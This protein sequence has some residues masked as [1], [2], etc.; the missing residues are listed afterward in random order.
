MKLENARKLVK[1]ELLDEET[2]LQ[3]DSINE[4]K[5][6]DIEEEKKLENKLSDLHTESTLGQE[7]VVKPKLA[8][9]KKN[10][11]TN[12]IHNF[13]PKS[14]ISSVKEDGKNKSQNSTR[15]SDSF[16]K[17]RSTFKIRSKPKVEN[18]IE[19][20]NSLGRGKSF[21]RR[22]NKT[23]DYSTTQKPKS[24]SIRRS[25][26]NT[27]ENKLK[28]STSSRKPISRY[29]NAS[30]GKSGSKY[31]F[32]RTSTTNQINSNSIGE[33]TENPVTMK[34]YISVTR[35]LSTT[36]SEEISTKKLR[37]K[38]FNDLSRSSVDETRLLKTKKEPTKINETTT[39]PTTTLATKNVRPTS[40][41]SRN[42]VQVFK[43]D[44]I[45]KSNVTNS[46]QSEKKIVN[47]TQKI[48]PRSRT[49]TYRRHSEV[50]QSLL[51]S[52]TVEPN[53]IEITP[54]ATRFQVS[55]SNPSPQLVTQEPVV[56]VKVSNDSNSV[57]QQSLQILQDGNTFTG[58]SGNI[59]N[60]T[61][62]V[63]VTAGNVTLLEQIRGTV[64][65]LLGS[66]GARSPIFSGI[67]N[68]ASNIVRFEIF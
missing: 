48:D 46:D 42:K 4:R 3:T 63:L 11:E 68:N 65:P 17:S 52:S 34:N 5:N 12:K 41:Y 13:T 9:P 31:K 15:N 37:T 44:S 57:Q 33:I 8:R 18:R 30:T 23:N 64:A 16:S 67:Y 61:K 49:A 10:D 7:S 40:R 21:T 29:R 54:K 56:N 53:S 38:L 66:L 47:S 2:N 27:E 26:K 45:L 35:S 1:P 51:R 50:A 60:P 28:S 24:T 58:N 20:N 22:T 59:F 25:L 32:S 6:L 39:T 19:A 62:N 43:T 36:I 14:R 55:T